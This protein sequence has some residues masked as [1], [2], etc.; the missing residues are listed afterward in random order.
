[1]SRS[2]ISHIDNFKA[3]VDV[4]LIIDSLAVPSLAETGARA[5]FQV[6]DV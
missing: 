3:L 4:A 5:L 1:M 6:D 2:N